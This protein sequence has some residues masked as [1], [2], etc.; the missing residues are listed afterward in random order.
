[1]ESA[2][3][4]HQHDQVEHNLAGTNSSCYGVT[5]S[6][7]WTP[8]ISLINGASTSGNIV[9]INSTDQSAHEYFP[10]F[11]EMLNSSHSTTA[12]KMI[13]KDHNTMSSSDLIP[14]NAHNLHQFYSHNSSIFGNFTQIHPTIDVS[15]FN[16]HM[17]LKAMDA[18]F[19]ATCIQFSSTD[20]GKLS[21]SFPNQITSE[22]KRSSILVEKPNATEAPT[23]KSRLDSRASCPPFKARKEKLGDRI[24]ALQQLVAP[25]GKTDTASVL[26]EAIGYIKFLQNQIESIKKKKKNKGQN[27]E[28]SQGILHPAKLLQIIK[29]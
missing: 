28:V 18:G 16:I 25:F 21:P 14:I 3:L 2:N 26:M 10:N 6:Q 5:T 13:N 22:E 20:L 1:M 23:K 15:N 29:R 7:A 12:M 4:H 8:N 27:G 11:T 17:N 19:N 24:A 9:S